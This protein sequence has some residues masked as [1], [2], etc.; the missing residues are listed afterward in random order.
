MDNMV[1]PQDDREISNQFDKLCRVDVTIEAA[2]KNPGIV[3][4]RT[5]VIDYFS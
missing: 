5:P 1:D 3:A 4:K 2:F